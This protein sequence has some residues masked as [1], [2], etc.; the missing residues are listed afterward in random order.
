MAWQNC[1]AEHAGAH[2]PIPAL[3]VICFLI[4][5]VT[6]WSGTLSAA[7][8]NALSPNTGDSIAS[9][10]LTIDSIIQQ[11]AYIKASNTDATRDFFGHSVA[12]SGDTLV[13]GAPNEDSN[14]TGINGDQSDN[15]AFAAGAVSVFTRS[16]TTW[17][18]QAYLK[19]SNANDLDY[20]G[21][22]VAVSGDTLVVGAIGEDSKVTGINGDQSDNSETDA[23][24]VYVFIRN[25]R[26]WS[27]QA[28][29]KASSTDRS[30]EFYQGGDEFGRSVAISGDTLVVGATREDSNATGVNGDPSDNSALDSGAAYVFTRNGATWSQQAYLKASN[31]GGA[32]Q[33]G[34][35]LGDS[36]GGSVAIAGNTVVVGAAAEDSNSTG[37][38]GDQFDDSA[39][40]AGAAY[41]FSDPLGFT[42]NAG[43][44]GA[45]YNPDTSGQGQLIEVVPEDQFMFLA[46]F[47]F[48]DASSSNPDQQHWYTAQGN[49]SGN[50][51]ELALHETL[52]GQFDDPQQ[53]STNPV[54]TVTVSFTDCEQGKMTY[55]IDTDGRQ[56][57]VPLERVIPGSGNVCEEH[58]G[59]A[60]ITTEAADINAGM[61]GAW[62]NNDTLGQGFLIDAHSD[63]DGGNFI[64]VAWFTY[65]D[66]T[67]SGQRW[68]T[69]QGNFEGSTAEIDIHETTGGSFDDA[70]LFD[71]DKVGTMTI[72]F[73]DCS[74]ALLTYSLT[75][76]G[77]ASDMAISRLIPDGQAL[78]EELYWV[79]VLNRYRGSQ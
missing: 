53:T 78:C 64:F 75:D 61:D 23:G 49:Y 45:W 36:F 21:W 38:N 46:W 42:I 7:Q 11:Q 40:D 22:S 5:A 9:Y 47:T 32:D 51:A 62:A 17:S 58:S 6:A 54:G 16:G 35:G 19:A 27:Q 26:I 1:C 18:Q 4:A 33:S 79:D 70:Q 13:V 73:T 50:T 77:L 28:Y 65:G 24:A 25:D 52:G 41:V 29:L 44:S 63:P 76:E 12:I 72:D 31:T 39:E 37:I 67:A 10:P 68:L 60:A 66:D 48:T 30:D 69:A 2:K 8:A 71:V 56:G 55:S 74:N 20:F 57:T 34:A 59:K 3:A 43:H 14:T 15:S